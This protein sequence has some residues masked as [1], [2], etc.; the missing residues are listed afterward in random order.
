MEFDERELFFDNLPLELE[1]KTIFFCGDLH[2]RQWDYRILWV[3]HKIIESKADLILFSG[4]M[5]EESGIHLLE[6]F[7]S[8]FSHCS[9]SSTL[10]KLFAPLGMFFVPG[11]NENGL[12]DKASV[13]RIFEEMNFVVLLNAFFRRSINKRKR[14][15][16]SKF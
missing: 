3:Q 2:L 5:V 14:C 15:R 6:D 4:D 13:F 7:L 12:I 10:D 9:E 11:N 16:I 1:G 8:P